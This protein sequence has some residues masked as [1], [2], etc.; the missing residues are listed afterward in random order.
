MVHINAIFKYKNDVFRAVLL[1]L[2][3]V[4]TV[5]IYEDVV[6]PRKHTR[7]HNYV[8]HDIVLPRPTGEDVS[9]LPIIYLI[10][11]TYLRLT[12]K[13]DLIRFIYTMRQVPRIHWIV[14]EDANEKSE[15]IHRL[16]K[17][18]GFSFTHLNVKSVKNET[19]GNKSGV[20]QRNLALSW[21]RNN[22]TPTDEGVVYFADDDNTYDIR[23]F[24]LMRETKKVSVWAVALAGWCSF[25]NMKVVDGKVVDWYVCWD[26]KRPFAVDMAGFAV[27][28]GLIHRRPEA[29]FYYDVKVGRLESSFIQRLGITMADL[30][31]V[32]NNFTEVLVW[33]TK[34]WI[35]YANGRARPPPKSPYLE[36]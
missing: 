14:I 19:T 32:A 31:P 16:G 30:E 5:S 10:T 22:T 29:N 33:H 18:S 4:I 35:K 24:E 13:A 20:L 7:T 21:I 8:R 15:L 6:T 11:P 25:E 34:T 36:V 27:N 12:Q 2:I 26:P 1:V 28:L 9:D 3:W 23:L 17:L